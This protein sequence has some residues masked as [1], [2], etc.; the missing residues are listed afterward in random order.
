MK[1]LSKAVKK[2]E[3]QCPK[4]VDLQNK[5]GYERMKILVTGEV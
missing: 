2:L 4:L 5:F 1:P 3:L